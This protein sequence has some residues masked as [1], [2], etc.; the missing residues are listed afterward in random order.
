MVEGEKAAMGKRI[1]MKGEGK[2]EYLD[3][4][5]RFYKC[6]NWNAI[7][8]DVTE[9][10]CFHPEYPPPPHTQADHDYIETFNEKF[11]EACNRASSNKSG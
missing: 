8:D 11:T 3:G 10:I 9:I 4:T 2:Y 7:P 6:D 1:E 5:G